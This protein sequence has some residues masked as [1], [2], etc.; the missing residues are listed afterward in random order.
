[1]AAGVVD[2]RLSPDLPEG[3]VKLAS[4]LKQGICRESIDIFSLPIRGQDG[5]PVRAE[6]N[7]LRLEQIMAMD[8]LVENVA[9]SIPAYDELKPF[10]K[11]TVDV[12][13]VDRSTKERP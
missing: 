11:A 5:A 8:Y 3:V 10:S 9:G 2:V 12:M 13:G 1:M 4:W 6:G 7:A